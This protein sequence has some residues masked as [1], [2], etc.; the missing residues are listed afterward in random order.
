MKKSFF[1]FGVV[2]L[3][4]VGCADEGQGDIGVVATALTGNCSGLPGGSPLG[5]IDRIEVTV[6]ERSGK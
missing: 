6:N 5:S 4:L 3:L 1:A 2:A